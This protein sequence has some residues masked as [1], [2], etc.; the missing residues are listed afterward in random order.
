[1]V[2]IMGSSL[3][4][5]NSV[6]GSSSV[7]L[8]SGFISFLLSCLGPSVCFKRD[9]RD[10]RDDIIHSAVIVVCFLTVVTGLVFLGRRGVSEEDTPSLV[11][12]LF[13]VFDAV[14]LQQAGDI[15]IEVPGK[16]VGGKVLL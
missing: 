9:G 14:F 13:L 6:V 5:R 8:N 16:Y 10:D 7:E 1:M 3:S 2:I 4:E 12:G 11:L 15:D